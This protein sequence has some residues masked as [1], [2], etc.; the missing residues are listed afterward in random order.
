MPDVSHALHER[1]VGN[2]D[3]LPDRLDQLLL[4][5]DAAR[6]FG[7]ITQDIKGLGAQ[8]QLVIAAPKRALLQVQHVAVEA[9]CRW[10]ARHL[11][12]TAP[13]V[14]IHRNFGQ[15]SSPSRYELVGGEQNISGR[16][17]GPPV[18]AHRRSARDDFSFKRRQF[19]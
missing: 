9:N 3:A 13:G 12:L 2:E 4:G 17:G 1:V 8:F 11:P 19:S 16:S 7:Q 14:M 10:G 6:V 15:I 18:T 5:N